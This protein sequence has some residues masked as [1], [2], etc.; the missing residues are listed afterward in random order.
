M[1]PRDHV[2]GLIQQLYAA[3][4]TTDGW[5]T[6]LDA[7][8]VAVNGSAASLIS[9]R[10]EAHQGNITVNAH[11]DPEALRL[12]D[13]H[14]GSADPWAYSPKLQVS[15]QSV[16]LGDELV[17]HWDVQRTAYYQ[18]F[19]RRYD[20]ARTVAVMV[21]VGPDALSVVSINASERRGPFGQREVAL[22][23]PLVPHIRRAIHLHRRLVTADA[24]SDNLASV[25][26]ASH[27]AV[28]LVD[29]SGR[30]S[31]MNAAAS[32]LNS[33]RD[34]LAVEHGDLR[35]SRTGDTMRLRSIIA[36]SI[37]TSNGQGIGVGGRLVLGRPSGR[38][39]LVVFVCPVS[40]Q[41]PMFPGVE[42]ASAAVFVTDPE[43]VDVPD[44]DMLCAVL[45]LTRAEGKL[46]HLLV[47]GINLMDAGT[48]L[49]VRRETIR[50]RLKTIFEKTNT[51]RQADLVRLVLNGTPRF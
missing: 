10:L 11:A 18:N 5:H 21:E 30:V 27:R 36:T 48:R 19:A 4:G 51:H 7:L 26:N 33:I 25:L 23:Q 34:G 3:P 41:R 2:L 43:R 49:G 46:T 12:Y 16:V 9:H 22:L 17:P 14:W 37:K 24:V 45:G 29:A 20:I 42:S 50:S 39:P 32:Q 47:Q 8:R 1:G 40:R 35:A 44:E 6:F 38:R 28:L 13:Q 15:R 31:F